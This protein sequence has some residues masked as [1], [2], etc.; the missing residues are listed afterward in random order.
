LG[1]QRTTAEHEPSTGYMMNA[2]Q[3]KRKQYDAKAG[4]TT[5]TPK[6][7]AEEDGFDSQSRGS[8]IQ[9]HLS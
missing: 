9:Q 6:V 4:I 2:V 7:H 8:M 3:R 1:D 5:T